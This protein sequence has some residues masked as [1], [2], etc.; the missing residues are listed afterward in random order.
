M[1]TREVERS[2]F[3]ERGWLVDW[4]GGGYGWERERVNVLVERLVYFFGTA[5]VFV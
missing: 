5:G 3:G 2:L 4:L 1:S